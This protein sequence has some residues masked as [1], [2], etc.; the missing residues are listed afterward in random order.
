LTDIDCTRS[1]AAP[2]GMWNIQWF[3]ML[4]ADVISMPDKWEYPLYAA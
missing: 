4:N 3:Q 1:Q 2:G